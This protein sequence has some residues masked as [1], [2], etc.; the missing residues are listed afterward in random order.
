MTPARAALAGAGLLV[1]LFLSVVWWRVDV[2]RCACELCPDEHCLYTDHLSAALAAPGSGAV[3]TMATFARGFI[4]AQVPLPSLL[5]AVPALLLPATVSLALVGAATTLL[6]WWCVRRIVVTAWRPDSTTLALLAVAFFGSAAVVRG[7]AR[8]ITDPVGM[9]CSIASLLAIERH[10]ERR[11]SASAALLATVQLV[12]LFSRVSFIPMLGMPV[13][14]ELL[15][16]GTAAERLRRALHAGIAFGLVPGAAYFAIVAVLGIEHTAWMWHSAHLP[17]YI[18][19][20]RPRELLV[21]LV[22]AGGPYLALGAL[23][24]LVPAWCRGRTLHLHLAWIALYTAFLY[25]GG[26]ALWL[27]YFAPIAPSVVV[28]ATPALAALVHRRRTAAVALV[29]VAAALQLAAVAR[30]IGDPRPL[31]APRSVERVPA[32]SSR[33][34]ASV[35]RRARS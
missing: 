24:L 3:G 33:L 6:A 32:A 20:D 18:P 2:L 16:S 25:L 22:I 35:S 13:L 19:A 9:A 30:W 15:A 1:A 27:R 34:A 4:H 21:T 31:L 14:A 12:G 23:A 29:A 8:P 5:A 11:S 17:Q 10:L 26:G 7:F 28:V